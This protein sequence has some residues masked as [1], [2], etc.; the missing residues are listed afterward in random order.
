MFWCKAQRPAGLPPEQQIDPRYS[1]ARNPEGRGRLL[2]IGDSFTGAPVRYFQQHFAEVHRVISTTVDGDLVARIK[3][4]V[5]LVL[6]VERNLERLLLPMVNLREAV[7]AWR[8]VNSTPN[9]PPSRQTTRH[10]SRTSTPPRDSESVN[11]SG[12]SRSE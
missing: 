3:P 1:V 9:S 10:S 8:P 12:I 7:P 4:D 5:V 2:V 11:R 6:A